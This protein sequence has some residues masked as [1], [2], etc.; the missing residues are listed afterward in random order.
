MPN[1]LP[2]YA[3][4]KNN[5]ITYFTPFRKVRHFAEYLKSK[6]HEHKCKTSTSDVDN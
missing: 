4:K 1:K 2:Q 5:E 6:S 3:R